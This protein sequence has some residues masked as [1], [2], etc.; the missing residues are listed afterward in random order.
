[1][2]FFIKEG[3]QNLEQLDIAR[4]RKDFPVLQRQV[5]GKPLIYLDSAASSQKPQAMIDRINELYSHEYARVEEGYTLSNEATDAFEE[6]RAKVARLVNAA[7]PRE[8]IFCRGATEGLNLIARIFE[9]DSL[10]GGDE[11][12]AE[13][14]LKALGA[15]E[16]VRASFMFYNTREEAETLAAA[17]EKISRQ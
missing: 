5:N 7:E 1:L 4:L 11:V 15:K 16:A 10:Q 14:L 6:T 2:A 12:A 3:N 8:I 9:Q 17:V 13:P